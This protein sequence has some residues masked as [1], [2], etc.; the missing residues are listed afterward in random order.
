[1]LNYTTSNGGAFASANISI[2]GAA[3]PPPVSDDT[4]VVLVGTSTYL[5]VLRNDVERGIYVNISDISTPALARPISG[6]NA[7]LVTECPLLDE[8]RWPLNCILYT[9]P[10]TL[11]GG[12][13]S[14]DDAFTYTVSDIVNGASSTARVA[15]KVVVPPTAKDDVYYNVDLGGSRVR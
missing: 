10:P 11:L 6:S 9:A 3:L 5:R 8:D 14:A 1:M 13:T 12:A 7:V 4:A 15:V 2:T